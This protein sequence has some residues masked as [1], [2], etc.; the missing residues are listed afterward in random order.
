MAVRS[1]PYWSLYSMA[2]SGRNAYIKCMAV[3]QVCLLVDS[4][5]RFSGKRCLGYGGECMMWHLFNCR[6]VFANNQSR[7]LQE[8]SHVKLLSWAPGPLETDMSAVCVS[9]PSTSCSSLWLPLARCHLSGSAGLIIFMSWSCPLRRSGR[10]SG[11]R[12]RKWPLMT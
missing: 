1:Y 7:W 2:K 10:P 11:T 4:R 12:H 9:Y 8:N 3:E 5:T 6:P